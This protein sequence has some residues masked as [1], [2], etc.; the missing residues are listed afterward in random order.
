[1]MTR[2]PIMPVSTTRRLLV[3]GGLATCVLLLWLTS[4]YRPSAVDR[5]KHRLLGRKTMTERMAQIGPAARARL[6]PRFEAAQVP[7]PPDAV[8]LVAFKDERVVSIYARGGEPPRPWRHVQDLP[9]L[10]MSGQLGPKLRRG[11]G[12]IPEGFYRVTA[13]NPNSAYHVS[14]KLSYPND[15]DRAQGRAERRHDL[16][17]DIFIHGGALSEGCLAVGD[18]GAEDLFVLVADADPKIVEVW[19]SPVDLRREA[20]PAT[21]DAQPAWVKQRYARLAQQLSTLP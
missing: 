10:A 12:Q 19:I 5:A 21:L 15:E 13:F 11:D 7:Y 14:M 8:R 20:L 17:D 16:G 1:M 2:I 18:Q 3:V 4:D 6:R 9:L